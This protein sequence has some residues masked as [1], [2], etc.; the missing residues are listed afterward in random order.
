[1]AYIPVAENLFVPEYI[2]RAENGLLLALN[3][4]KVGSILKVSIGTIEGQ[5]TS[6]N[7]SAHYK[8]FTA[9]LAPEGYQSLDGINEEILRFEI[10]SLERACEKLNK[11]WASKG[12]PD[13][14]YG[15]DF[16]ILINGRA[17]VMPTTPACFK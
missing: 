17:K 3:F 5:P 10:Q 12:L 14:I 16:Y 13:R 2:K 6:G 11:V 8:P 7:D 4:G 9:C 1:M 15:D